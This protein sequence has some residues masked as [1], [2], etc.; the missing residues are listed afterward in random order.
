MLTKVGHFYIFTIIGCLPETH[1]ITHGNV[2]CLGMP[3]FS[4]N[5]R[6]FSD[7]S[8][9]FTKYRKS[10][11]LSPQSLPKM[12]FICMLLFVL[13][14][15]VIAH[16]S[17]NTHDFLYPAIPPYY[18]SGREILLYKT[19]KFKPIRVTVCILVVRFSIYSSTSI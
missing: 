9:L 7:F 5:Q 1:F 12:P 19:S 8:S 11:V 3:D 10:P 4:P 2:L 14:G 18:G 17:S 16:C 15:K 6:L 13:D